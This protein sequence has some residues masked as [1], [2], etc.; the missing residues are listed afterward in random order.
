MRFRQVYHLDLI[1]SQEGGPPRRLTWT[2]PPAGLHDGCGWSVA[3]TFHSRQGQ[4]CELRATAPESVPA[5]FLYSIGLT[6][7]LE[8]FGRYFAE[9]AEQIPLLSV[10]AQPLAADQP[11]EP[12]EAA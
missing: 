9:H 10:A 2:A 8:R 5:D 3:V 11:P 4:R 12:R 7:V 1:V 6:R